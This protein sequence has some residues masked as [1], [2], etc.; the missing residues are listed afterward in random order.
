MIA[1]VQGFFWP[2]IFWDFTTRRLDKIVTP[3][4]LLQTLNLITAMFV[5]MWQMPFPCLASV[6]FHRRM[7]ALCV[8]LPCAFLF[9][10]LLYQGTEPAV[11]YLVSFVL[12]FLAYKDQELHFDSSSWRL[13]VPLELIIPKTIVVTVLSSECQNMLYGLLYHGWSKGVR[14]QL[15]EI[16]WDLTL[17]DQ[18]RGK[19]RSWSWFSKCWGLTWPYS[20]KE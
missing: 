16:N 7:V 12:Y 18:L 20:G 14:N 6:A 4:P 11:F 5:I 19:L 3:V 9:S 17:P 13:H 1:A 2:K 8:L 15:Y 10:A